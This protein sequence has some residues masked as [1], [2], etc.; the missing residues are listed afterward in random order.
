[1]VILVV[2]VVTPQL[3]LQPGTK[4]GGKSRFGNGSSCGIYGI[5]NITCNSNGT[6]R[7]KHR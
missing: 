3:C 2:L 7:T 4:S 5:C 6:R 1:M